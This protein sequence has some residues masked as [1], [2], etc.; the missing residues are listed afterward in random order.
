MEKRNGKR[1]R[2]EEIK[3]TNYFLQ[4]EMGKGK[5]KN[6]SIPPT[7]AS[8]IHTNNLINTVRTHRNVNLLETWTR[9]DT[10]RRGVVTKHRS[11]SIHSPEL[12]DI[13]D[14]A[15]S[16]WARGEL[17]VLLIE[18]KVEGEGGRG[19]EGEGE[20]EGRERGSRRGEGEGEMERERWRGRDGEGEMER[21]R[22]RGRDGERD[23]EV[24]MER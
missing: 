19:R 11:C 8:V 10:P 4:R 24:E 21:E 18:R 17:K 5:Q 9:D 16:H 7:S 12:S 3:I 2:N 13:C 14:C 23:G 15:H 1:G 6:S 22:G 20:E